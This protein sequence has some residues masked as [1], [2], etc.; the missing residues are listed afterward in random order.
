MSK[1]TDKERRVLLEWC[2]TEGLVEYLERI[3]AFKIDMASDKF[4]IVEKEYYHELNKRI[5]RCRALLENHDDALIYYT[6]AELYERDNIGISRDRTLKKKTRYYAI[7]AIRKDRNFA[8]AWRLLSEAYSWIAL[9]A[10]EVWKEPEDPVYRSKSKG[11]C[12]IE[13]AIFCIKKAIKLVPYDL[14]YKYLLRKY[15]HF[16]NEEYKPD[17]AIREL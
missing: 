8:D 1:L 10:Y 2:D 6:L 3:G 15:Y 4:A 17:D 13:K 16:R 14:H 9:I 5:A 12:Y 7:K 11:I